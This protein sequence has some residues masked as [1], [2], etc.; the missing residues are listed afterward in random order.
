MSFVPHFFLS[1]EREG[2]SRCQSSPPHHRLNSRPFDAMPSVFLVYSFNPL[3]RWHPLRQSPLAWG[4]LFLLQA[5]PY[6]WLSFLRWWSALSSPSISGSLQDTFHP[7]GATSPMSVGGLAH[8][9][10]G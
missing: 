3:P 9:P 10:D 4:Q 2:A 8:R 7:Q 5:G 1:M 6:P